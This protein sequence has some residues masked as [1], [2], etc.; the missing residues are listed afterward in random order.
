MNPDGLSYMDM[1]NAYAQGDWHNALNTYWS[2]FYSWLLGIT[3]RV[4]KPSRYWHF[5]AVHSVNYVVFLFAI[6][7]FDFFLVQIRSSEETATGNTTLKPKGVLPLW[8]WIIIGYSLFIW[9]ALEMIVIAWATPD[10]CVAT[11]VFFTAGWVIRTRRKGLSY[12]RAIVLGITLGLGYLIK[13]AMLPVG[14]MF[15][16]FHFFYVRRSPLIKN[17]AVIVIALYIVTITPYITALSISKGRFT[18]GD[19]AKLNYSWWVN[20]NT[21]FMHWQGNIEG[22]GTPTH[23]TRLILEQPAVYEFAS[24]VSGTFPPWY[25]P[26]YWYDGVKVYFN[27]SQQIKAILVNADIYLTTFLYI[28]A[29]RLV[30]FF[31]V[32]ILIICRKNLRTNILINRL[33]VIAPSIFTLCMYL[34]VIVEPR[35]V[36]AFCVIILL[37]IFSSLRV[38]NHLISLRI[39][40]YSILVPL[41][42]IM[43]VAVKP[44]RGAYS[45]IHDLS[46]HRNNHEHYLIAE[47]LT[48]KGIQPGDGVSAVGYS[49]YPYWAYLTKIHVIAEIPSTSSMTLSRN[50]SIVAAFS[51][52]GAKAIV[53]YKLPP[54]FLPL[55]WQHIEG[56]N[57]YV[58]FLQKIE[59]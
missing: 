20:R 46:T 29:S 55:G 54:E 28:R 47:Y 5:F 21:V 26:S 38:P 18:T 8:M 32:S 7:S 27:L 57:A 14:L 39:L 16:L 30:F 56:T 50:S 19:A 43:L 1:G 41:A 22:S 31:V 4:I 59:H 42:I 25:D 51:S 37:G 49:F 11:F 12:F 6:A 58:Y 44:V 45:V 53:A 40:N 24:P 17:Y 35:Y 2:P 52:T 10:M 3:L 13:A 23:P 34:L 15:L 48:L 9:A 33:D 36:G